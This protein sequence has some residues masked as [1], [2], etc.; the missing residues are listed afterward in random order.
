MKI[1]QYLTDYNNRPSKT[2]TFMSVIT[3]T[4][5][6]I[7][8]EFAFLLFLQTHRETDRFFAVSGV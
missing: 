6:R 3:S 4:S 1:R 7:H 5:R 8:N 2:I